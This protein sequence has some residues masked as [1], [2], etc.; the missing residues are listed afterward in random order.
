MSDSAGSG[1]QEPEHE[2]AV[3]QHV[4]KGS[5][6]RPG[7]KAQL[8]MKLPADDVQVRC[9]FSSISMAVPGRYLLQLFLPFCIKDEAESVKFSSK[10]QPPTLIVT[11]AVDSS[12]IMVPSAAPA[13]AAVQAHGAGAA[14]LP[15]GSHGMRRR[16]RPL[17]QQQQQ[18]QA[19][20][21]H[22]SNSSSSTSSAEDADAELMDMLGGP[23]YGDNRSKWLLPYALAYN[24]LDSVGEPAFASLMWR[25]L[26]YSSQPE[27]T[28]APQLLPL[29]LR[30]VGR[31]LAAG[32]LLLLLLTA[33]HYILGYGI[34]Q[35]L[36]C[37]V[38]RGSSVSSELLPAFKAFARAL[39]QDN[40][41]PPTLLKLLA[42]WLTYSTL[43][44]LAAWLRIGVVLGWA[45]RS[46]LWPVLLGHFWRPRVYV[47]VPLMFVGLN[48]ASSIA[49]TDI[50]EDPLFCF[51]G[52]YTVTQLTGD[53][54]GRML[55]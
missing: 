47:T 10:K 40:S 45:W 14:A 4:H 16:L 39:D 49:T 3:V 5:I 15:F 51:V 6:D 53:S 35:A 12:S 54:K 25:M 50:P 17:R 28:A 42:S 23:M 34:P 55:A 26:P 31:A 11:T 29:M 7:T 30:N 33:S 22:N 37:R 20:D 52:D 1:P 43:W 2:L 27:Y 9:T 24:W 19:G 21:Q 18:H 44:R 41:L 48:V 46:V 13:P 32:L 36:A 38:L 8:T